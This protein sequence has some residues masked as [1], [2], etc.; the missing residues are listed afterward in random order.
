MALPQNPPTFTAV[1]T[2]S[3]E[4]SIELNDAN[5]ETKAWKLSRYEGC[6]TKTQVLNRKTV[7]DIT[8]G[9]PAVQKYSRNIYWGNGIT[10][11][12]EE[13]PKLVNFPQFSYVQTNT[14]YT[15]NDDDTVTTNR[16]ESKKDNFDERR[17][18]Y[19]A[20]YEDFPEG[21]GCKVIVND[22][23]IKTNLKDRY[24]IFFN[25]GQLQKILHLQ[26]PP[27]HIIPDTAVQTYSLIGYLTQSTTT[28][29]YYGGAGGNWIPNTSSLT[30][31]FYLGG[32]LGTSQYT[33]SLFNTEL[34]TTWY[35]GSFV[36]EDVSLSPGYTIA[37][38][39]DLE[40]LTP[41]FT[42]F[43]NY[44]ANSSYIGDK[45]LFG[46]LSQYHPISNF[47]N[48]TT[49]NLKPIYTNE[50]GSYIGRGSLNENINLLSTIEITYAT[51]SFISLVNQ[52]EL[53]TNTSL[54]NL[55]QNYH[56]KLGGSPGDAF[57][58]RI[59]PS[60]FATGSLIISLLDDSNPSLLLNLPKNEH[61]KDGIGQRGFVIIPENLHPH[62]KKN[63]T[64]Y[65][66]KAGVPLGIPLPPAPDNE[67]KQ[68]K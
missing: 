49:P 67:F 12:G 6:Q 21:S 54:G 3:K 40:K 5:L 23:S 35:T 30:G 68:L 13:N 44:K 24:T 2:G 63:L 51:S 32:V 58:S 31:S 28:G 15:I 42:D 37:S 59:Q 46:T 41:F 47:E 7:G 48:P 38:S 65:L 22:E 4:Y 56:N 43:F 26:S 33:S 17:G 10:D 53:H 19:R 1:T 62:I 60:N 66:F 27:Y 34:Y 36:G 55:P 25:Q 8:H 57:I 16:L 18:F 39:V 45:K 64:Y 9:G 11:T 14:Y 20:F 50:S 52:I 61:L 29:T